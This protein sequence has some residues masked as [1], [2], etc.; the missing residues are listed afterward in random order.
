MLSEC[1]LILINQNAWFRLCDSLSAIP[2]LGRNG[3]IFFE[4]VVFSSPSAFSLYVRRKINPSR[5]IDDGWSS[6]KFDGHLLETYRSRL[7]SMNDSSPLKTST[8]KPGSP[9]ARGKRSRKARTIATVHPSLAPGDN[10]A[11]VEAH[12]LNEADSTQVKGFCSVDARDHVTTLEAKGDEINGVGEGEP[13]GCM[14]LQ[15]P[16]SISLQQWHPGDETWVS[17]DNCQKWRRIRTSM[18]SDSAWFC[19][20]NPDRR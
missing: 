12:G 17:C 20:D 9:A 15:G 5:R 18:I 13:D 11:T 10:P 8:P 14:D 2:D 19:T 4:G 16:R 1:P 3:E 7:G 6:V